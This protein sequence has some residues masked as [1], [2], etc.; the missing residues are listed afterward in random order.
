[1]TWLSVEQQILATAQQFGT[2]PVDAK[3]LEALKQH[4]RYEFALSL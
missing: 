3:K 1:M 4:L 2:A